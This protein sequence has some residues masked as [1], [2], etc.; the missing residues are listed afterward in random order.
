MKNCFEAI[1]LILLFI[2]F[3]LQAKTLDQALDEASRHFTGVGI[4]TQPSQQ[5]V[6]DVVNYHSGQKDTI[7]KKI[8]TELYLALERHFPKFKLILLSESLSGISSKNAVFIKGTYEPSGEITKIRLQAVSGLKDGE[9]LSQI[10]VSF[11]TETK[12]ERTLVAVLDF[13]APDL[14]ERQVKGFSEMFHSMIVNKNAFDLSSS[15]DVDKMKPESIQKQQDCTRDECATIIGQSLGVDR[16]ISSSIISMGDNNWLISSKMINIKDESIITLETVTPS[17]GLNSFRKALEELVD[18]LIGDVKPVFK[19][20]NEERGDLFITSTPKGAS[21]RVNEVKFKEKSDTYLKGIPAGKHSLTLVKG[22]LGIVKEIEILPNQINKYDLVLKPLKSELKIL[23]SPFGAAVFIDGIAMGKSP[24]SVALKAGTHHI[25]ISNKGYLDHNQ[26]IDLKPLTPLNLDI[27]LIKLLTLKLN[28]FPPDSK[29]II[30]GKDYSKQIYF[31]QNEPQKYSIDLPGGQYK[32]HVSHPDSVE[33][34]TETINLKEGTGKTV[35]NVHLR[36]SDTYYDKGY[37][38][39]LKIRKWKFWSSVSLG[40]LATF[41]SYLENQKALQAQNEMESEMRKMQ[42]AYFYDEAETYYN[43]AQ[44]FSEPINKHNENSQT[45][46]LLSTLLF[47]YATWVWFD[48]PQPPIKPLLS[49]DINR[50]GAI[51]LSTRY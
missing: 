17:G 33:S 8:E 3:P 45:G 47:G 36:W 18:K 39:A 14:D 35:K 15:A 2:P 1:F 48:E 23:S 5:F 44:L 11:E 40:V 38:S 9:I 6:I 51:S 41:Y 43:Q 37:K 46:M 28:I 27:K 19:D 25:K 24:L 12:R 32:V 4:E 10:S 31:S 16:V 20:K 30:N 13:E 7:S 49:F 34:F 22:H 21:I 26:S 42:N 29:V 50:G